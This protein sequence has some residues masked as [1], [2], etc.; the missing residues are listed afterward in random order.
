MTQLMHRSAEGAPLTLE[1]VPAAHITHAL[2]AYAPRTVVYLPKPHA[3]QALE[4]AAA[5]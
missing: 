3:V 4:P 2:S 1:D 5:A